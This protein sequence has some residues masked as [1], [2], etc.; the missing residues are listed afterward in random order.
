[1][2]A[3]V[4]QRRDIASRWAKVNPI[5]QQGEVGY[6]TDTRQ[7]KIGN[8]VTP[9]NDLPYDGNPCVQQRGDSEVFTMSQ[10]AITKEL[11]AYDNTIGSI[12]IECGNARSKYGG[13]PAID[14]GNARTV[15]TN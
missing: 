5:L 8:G 1:M 11:D 7:R 3:I 6:E 10:A 13:S 2:A 4:Q 12:R 14:Y 9:W 15:V